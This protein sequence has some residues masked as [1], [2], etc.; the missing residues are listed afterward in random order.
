MDAED[1]FEMGM[2]LGDHDNTIPMPMTR[3]GKLG[4]ADSQS[5]DNSTPVI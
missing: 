5:G 4:T 3:A 2:S 1:E